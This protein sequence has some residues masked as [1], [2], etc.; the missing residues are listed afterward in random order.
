MSETVLDNKDLELKIHLLFET[1]KQHKK[2]FASHH[3]SEIKVNLLS[4]NFEHLFSRVRDFCDSI[5]G[6]SRELED[7][8][9]ETYRSHDI[10]TAP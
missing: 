5:T 7:I 8:V 9:S 2:I 4:D 1:L 6:Y 3:S 10:I